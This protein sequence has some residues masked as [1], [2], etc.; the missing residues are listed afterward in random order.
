MRRVC[1]LAED[2]SSVDPCTVALLR[3]HDFEVKEIPHNRALLQ[4]EVYDFI[5]EA[6]AVIAGSER[7]DAALLDKLPNLKVIARRGVG[8]DNVDVTAAEQRGHPCNAHRRGRGRSCGRTDH[9]VCAGFCPASS[10]A[11]HGHEAGSLEAHA[12]HRPFRGKPSA[13]WA[14]VVLGRKSRGGPVPLA[15]G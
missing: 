15:C 4:E 9:G 8:F 11:G 3:D 1:I 14:L 10:P 5:R 6:D 7:Y 2:V 12:G 13:W